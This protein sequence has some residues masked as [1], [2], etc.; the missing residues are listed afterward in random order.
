MNN[1]PCDSVPITP[2][3]KVDALLEKYPQLENVLIEMTPA[4]AKLRN[5]VLRKTV[6]K[7]ATL[8]Q[9]AQIGN[10]SLGTLINRLRAEVGITDEV[11]VI[12]EEAGDPV[13]PPEWFDRSLVS[14][15]LDAREMIEAGEH[16]VQKVMKEIES[17]EQGKIYELVTPFVPAP[18]IDMVK[19]KGFLAWSAEEGTDLVKSYFTRG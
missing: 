5:P 4:F 16:P 7:L 1:M 12:E 9:V 8:S 13:T 11:G 19:G 6:A 3:T 2:E 10:V 14:K 15:T 17:L 18:L